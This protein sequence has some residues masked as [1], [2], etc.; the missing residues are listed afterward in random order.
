MRTT[1]KSTSYLELHPSLRT[2]RRNVIKR[3]CENRWS[4]DFFFADQRGIPTFVE[5]K[6]FLDTRARR[7]VIGQMF[8]YAANGHHYWTKSKLREYA[9][10]EGIDLEEEVRALA[11]KSGDSVED[12]LELV[13]NNLHEGQIRLVF[14]LE[15][16]PYELRSIVEP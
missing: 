10:Q 14:F 11:P 2:T 5:C 3:K 8:D 9:A 12:Y 13:E 4:V 7:E 6:R 1:K 16:S 15:E